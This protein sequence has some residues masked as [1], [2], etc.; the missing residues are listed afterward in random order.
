[1]RRITFGGANSLDNYLA[2][3]DHSVDWLMWGDEAAAVMA[4][5][6]TTIDTVLMGR[7][8]YEVAARSGQTSGYPGVKS[9]VFSHTLKQVPD[10]VTLVRTDAVGFVR[11][12]KK[13]EGKDICLMGGGELAQPL[14]EAGLIDEI[15]FNIHPMLLG[16]GIPLFHPMNRQIN[17]ELKECR[18]FTNGCV[19]VTYR[20]K[21]EA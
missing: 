6:W 9:Y 18:A 5:F 21:N 14:F 3:P 11:G 20:V 12:L 8:T 17:L 4:D 10:G 1:M 19:Y 16:S 13:E 2:R 7:K 15:G